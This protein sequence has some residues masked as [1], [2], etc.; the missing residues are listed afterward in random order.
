MTWQ[1]KG[2]RHA[3]GYG[4]AWVKLRARILARDGHLCRACMVNG[5]VTVATQVDH[6]LPKSKGGT[7]DE[8]NLQ[9]LCGP[10]HKAKTAQDE[11]RKLRRAVGV[12][13]YPIG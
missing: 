2:S 8:A 10:C 7:D 12:D 6:V 13:G 5:R 4:S 11:G 9:S 3:R 1:H